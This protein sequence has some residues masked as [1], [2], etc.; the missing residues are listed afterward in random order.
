MTHHFMTS[1]LLKIL[2]F[3]KFGDFL[4]DI[5]YKSRTDVFIDVIS[6]IINQW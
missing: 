3:D 5:D 6:L 2:K 4:C 1:S